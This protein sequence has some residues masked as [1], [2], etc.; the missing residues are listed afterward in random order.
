MADQTELDRTHM[1]LQQTMRSIA[2]TKATLKNEHIQHSE[3]VEELKHTINRAKAEIQSGT[4]PSAVEARKSLAERQSAQMLDIESKRAAIKFEIDELKQRIANNIKIHN[5]KVSSLESEVLELQ[6]KKTDV[7]SKNTTEMEETELELRKL[8][9]E[10]SKNKSVLDQ[11]EQRLQLEKIEQKQ[12]EQKENARL[13]E[14]A[15]TKVLEEK[16]HYAA[17]WIQLRWKSFKKRQLLKL[18][19]KSKKK[20]GKKKKKKS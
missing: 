20:G 1:E 7:L 5:Y 4:F 2:E 8:T 13:E 15:N 12:L 10:Y 16:K 19:T 3:D 9:E 11:L 17:L 18:A 6:Q 14:E